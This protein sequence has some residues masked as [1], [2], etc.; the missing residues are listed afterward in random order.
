MRCSPRRAGG[1]IRRRRRRRS[2]ACSG[3]RSTVE[4][5]KR[6]REPSLGRRPTDRLLAFLVRLE[7][8]EQGH[9]IIV[10]GVPSGLRDPEQVDV[11]SRNVS[12]SERLHDALPAQ[13]IYFALG[14]SD[15]VVPK[16]FF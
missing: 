1:T 10:E 4:T 9:M 13:S 3:A 2:C 5:G 7:R 14:L 11:F 15:A 8:T 12:S 16:A 6:R